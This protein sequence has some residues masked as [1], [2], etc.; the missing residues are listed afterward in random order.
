MKNA[1]LLAF[2]AGLL[3][4]I[5]AVW[6]AAR[7]RQTAPKWSFVLGMLVLALES[8]FSGLAAYSEQGGESVKYWQQWRL[9]A[10]SLL[11]GIWLMFSLSYARGNARDFLAAWRYTLVVAFVLPLSVACF[12]FRDL[13]WVGISSVEPDFRLLR[14]MKPGQALSIV[15]LIATVL[16]LMNLERTFRAA[17][18]TMRWRIKFII[19]GL[20]VLFA[21]RV[22]TSSYALLLRGPGIQESMLKIDSAGLALGCLLIMRSLARGTVEV[23]VYPPPTVFQN[24]LILLVAGIYLLIVGVFAKIVQWLGGDA[25]FPQKAFLILVALVAVTMV[26]MSDRVRLHTRRFFSRYFQRPLYD[27]RTVWRSFTEATASRVKQEEL[28]E[29]AVKQVAE[30]FQTLSVTIW[31]VDEKRENLHFAASTSH[32][33]ASLKEI[34]PQ[35]QEAAAIIRVF[36]EHHEPR[37]IESSKEEWAAVLRR[38]HP[39]QFRGGGSRVCVPMIAGRQVMGVMTLGDRVGGIFFSL[40]DFE[41]LKCVADQ[42]AAALLNAQLSQKLLQAKELEAFQTMSAFFVHDLKN[43]ASTLNLM[44]KNLPVHFDNPAFREDALRGV[45]KTCEHINHLISRLSQLRHDLQIRPAEM[46]LNDLITKSLASW[47]AADGVTLVR[48]FHPCPKIFI[49]QEQIHKVVTNLVLNAAEA[50][51]ASGKITVETSQNNGWAVV[52]VTDTGCGMDPEFL[53]RALFR[54]FQTT[55]KNGFGIGMFQSKMIV[56]AHGGRIEVESELKKGTTFRV[57]LPVQ[58]QSK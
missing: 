28:C 15:F 55:K 56:E 32:S 47:N 23:A 57:L 5:V 2:V 27:Y 16:T 39:T 21:E 11:P 48:N 58:K 25:T 35:K 31:L 52:A 37:D 44:L 34:G 14:L 51:G 46:D 53:R 8:L 12:F 6:G 33:A 9:A 22:Y 43:T 4:L 18:G 49:D 19:L 3:A 24:S 40:Q 1:A 42:M 10:M 20:G 38:C 45:A 54:P 7:G 30:I 26:G 50:V 36:Q 29:A 41:L 13:I 17:V